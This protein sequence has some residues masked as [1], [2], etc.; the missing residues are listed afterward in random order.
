MRKRLASR[1]RR[2]AEQ[3]VGLSAGR[4]R[5]SQSRRIVEIWRDR[6]VHGFWRALAVRAVRRA[7]D[8]E[9]VHLGDLCCVGR[10]N[11]V[12]PLRDVSLERLVDAPPRLR[13]RDREHG[14]SAS[15]WQRFRAPLRASTA[16]VR[17][18]TITATHGE[19]FG[20]SSV[21]SGDKV[22]ALRKGEQTRTDERSTNPRSSLQD[23]GRGSVDHSRRR[24]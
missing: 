8:I 13:A 15:C 22:V 14:D 18:E 1:R 3:I 16:C 20:N 12:F 24:P 5:S 11:G 4:T 21:D 10:S 2:R 17:E 9:V 7:S 6:S 19:A 23:E